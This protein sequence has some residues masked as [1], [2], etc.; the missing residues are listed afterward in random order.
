MSSTMSTELTMALTAARIGEDSIGT[1]VR[2]R[3]TSIKLLQNTPRK[4]L[5][6]MG[7]PSG[8]VTAMLIAVRKGKKTKKT[9]KAKKAK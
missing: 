4:E 5:L 2:Y 6:D 3:V 7:I 8:D 9:K 1:L